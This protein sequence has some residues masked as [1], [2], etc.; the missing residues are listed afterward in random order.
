M[1]IGSLASMETFRSMIENL[2][3]LSATEVGRLIARGRLDPVEVAEFFLG[4]IE[5][6]RDNP[7]F[8]LVT[9]KRALEEAAA[10]RKRHREGRAAGPLDGAPI[11]W[12]DLVDMAGERTTAGSAL[13]AD[14]A[15]KEKD[16]PIV[17]NL[18]AA[19]MVALGKTNLSEFAFSA[20]GLNPH[21]GTP[22]NPRD[23]VTPRIAGGSS[24]GAAV[25]VAGG[26]AP[27]AIG[28]DTGGSIRAPASFCGIVGFKTSE[29]RIDKQGV[30]PLS[31]TLD[32]IGPMAHT[33]E[34]CVL[35]DM[36][37]RG[38]SSPSARPI[39][40]SG[41][42]FVV[43]DKTGIDDAE[44]AVT[45]NLEAAMK[46]LAAAGAKVTSRPVRS[47]G[48]MRDLIALYGSLVAIEA[49]AE[50]RAI[51]DSADAERVDRRVV[52]RAVGGR[53]ASAHDA[54]NL[55]RGR[56]HLIAALTDD[57]KGALLVLPATPMTAPAIDA[58]ERDDEHFRVTN[59]RAIHYTFLGNLFRMCGLALPSGTDAAGLPTGVQFLAPS[60]DDERLLSIGL[61]MESAL[62][63]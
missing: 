30:F 53:A 60:G 10:S 40:L 46:R 22:R 44:A 42:E 8:I 41:V 45:A 48:A 9:R 18:S 19:G 57:L 58:L 56:E 32:T 2:E 62:S 6:D 31:R 14:S 17:T 11:A 3:K 27:C 15:P 13:F 54:I 51:F 20:L 16:A 4:R 37:L 12:K 5:R 59:L 49:Y 36:A 39:N 1:A 33:V 38:Q 63:R 29:G 55:Q 47:I 24:S 52:A 26:L 61:S 34:D 21:F 28:S 7:S 25:A 23:P 43:P 50:H 35:I